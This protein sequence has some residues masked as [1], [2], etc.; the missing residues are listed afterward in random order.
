MKHQVH[1]VRYDT[2]K[3]IRILGTQY[4]SMA[5]TAAAVLD[6]YERRGW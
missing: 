5:N 2:S 4:R 1:P 3:S 6:D